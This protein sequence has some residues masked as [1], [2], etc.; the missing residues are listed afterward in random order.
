MSDLRPRLALL[1]ALLFQIDFGQDWSSKC[2][3]SFRK[4]KVSCFYYYDLSRGLTIAS[5]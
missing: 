3:Y 1:F 5:S 4:K 2:I